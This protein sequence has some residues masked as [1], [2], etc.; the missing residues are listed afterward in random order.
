MEI[1][2]R[3]CAVFVEI[4][5]RLGSGASPKAVDEAFGAFWSGDILI[6]VEMLL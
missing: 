4:V 1:S 2:L 5:G 3:S 6:D